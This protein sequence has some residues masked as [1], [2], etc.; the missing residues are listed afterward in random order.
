M[1]GKVMHLYVF[2]CLCYVTDISTDMSEDQVA[3]ERDPDLNQEEDVRLDAIREQHWRDFYEEDENK[4]KIR[5]LRWG[6]YVKET[7]ESLGCQLHIRKRDKLFEL[8]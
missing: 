1:F 8:V 4:K 5:Y 7:E 2:Y 3:E 6:V